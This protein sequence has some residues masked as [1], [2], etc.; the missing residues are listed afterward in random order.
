MLENG[1]AQLVEILAPLVYRAVDLN[2][3]AGGRRKEVDDETADRLRAFETHAVHAPAAQGLPEDPLRP[4]LM[5]PE[6]SRNAHPMPAPHADRSTRR[7]AKLR[8][9]RDSYPGLFPLGRVIERLPQ[10]HLCLF[11]E[12]PLDGSGGH[13][14]TDPANVEA[15]SVEV[16]VEG[17][18][19]RDGLAAP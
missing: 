4:D 16:L 1:L 7:T 18:D 6:V 15:V 12:I 11:T 3:E 17:A 5:P 2:D 14:G 8:G 13:H 9:E 10:R 19:L